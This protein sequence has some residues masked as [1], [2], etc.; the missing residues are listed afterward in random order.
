MRNDGRTNYNLF[1]HLNKAIKII[2]NQAVILSSTTFMQIAIYA[3]DVI[4]KQINKRQNL[5]KIEYSNH[6]SFSTNVTIKFCTSTVNSFL[7]LWQYK[8][9]FF[10]IVDSCNLTFVFSPHFGQIIHCVF[11]ILL[12]II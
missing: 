8:R 12:K 11:V 2:Q 6:L 5:F 10:I 9:K 4:Q 3:F 7:H 1:S